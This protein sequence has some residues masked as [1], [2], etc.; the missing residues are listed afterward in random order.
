MALN[1]QSSSPSNKFTMI[2]DEALFGLTPNAY[3]LYAILK[4]LG[5][6]ATNSNVVLMKRTGL[7]NYACK[8]AKKELINKGWLATK[9]LYGNR[10]AFYIGKE[11]IKKY[12]YFK[13]IKEEKNEK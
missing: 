1:Y 5:S 11:A 4:N 8:K 3:F 2:E 12:K 10:Y 7:N 9:Q 13:Q 6:D